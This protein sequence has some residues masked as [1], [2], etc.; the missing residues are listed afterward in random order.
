M[1]SAKSIGREHAMDGIVDDA[2]WE[3]VLGTRSRALRGGGPNLAYLFMAG[4][5]GTTASSQFVASPRARL[6]RGPA[7]VLKLPL[8][9]RGQGREERVGM[10]AWTRADPANDDE[11]ACPT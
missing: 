1:T 4:G 11:V 10:G 2:P 3:G 6:R 5:P 9:Q 7:P 8:L